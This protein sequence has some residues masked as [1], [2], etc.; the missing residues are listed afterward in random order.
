MEPF[1]HPYPIFSAL[2]NLNFVTW[3]TL[4]FKVLQ[5]LPGTL[6]PTQNEPKEPK[7]TQINPHLDY[8]TGVH[9]LL[10][11]PAYRWFDLARS[12][13]QKLPNHATHLKSPEKDVQLPVIRCL[14]CSGGAV[15]RG[16]PV[17]AHEKIAPWSSRRFEDQN[18]KRPKHTEYRTVSCCKTISCT[19]RTP[20]FCPIFWYQGS[21]KT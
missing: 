10:E 17:F 20:R 9:I 12:D 6:S 16:R 11:D 13:F 5:I 1:L 18:T 3:R 2:L 21:L 4:K 7:R 15:L 19:R 14:W 8:E